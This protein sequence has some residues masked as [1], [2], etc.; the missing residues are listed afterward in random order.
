MNKASVVLLGLWVVFFSGS[1][2]LDLPESVAVKGDPGLY[3]PVGNIS[4]V[5]GENNIKISSY[6]SHEKIQEMMNKNDADSPI[7]VYE[8]EKS[9]LEA[10]TYLI[11]YPI[12]EMNLNLTEYVQAI[13]AA[14]S[15]PDSTEGFIQGTG[16]YISIPIPLGTMPQWI[17]TITNAQFTITLTMH[18]SGTVEVKFNKGPSADVEQ[19]KPFSEGGTVSFDS[20]PIPLFNPQ[21]G[22]T[23]SVKA[24]PGTSFSPS[25]D[26]DW[27]QAAVVPN[28][29]N[30]EGKFTGFLEDLDVTSLTRFL[31][32]VEFREVLGYVYVE[33]LPG[34]GSMAV[35]VDGDSLLDNGVPS[36]PIDP[37]SLPGLED[38]PSLGGSIGTINLTE[39]FNQDRSFKLGYAISM[40]EVTIQ[41]SSSLETIKADMV[42]KLPL[43]FLVSGEVVSL[44]DAAKYVK[45]DLKASNGNS[46]LPAFTDDL[47]GRKS[48]SS[49]NPIKS[50]D[51]ITV[52][53]KDIVNDVLPG[54]G[55]LITYEKNQQALTLT[56]GTTGELKLSDIPN[57]FIPRFDILLPAEESDEKGVLKIGRGNS[58]LD[59]FIAVEAK[60]KIEY[61]TTF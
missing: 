59:F 19:S 20:G 54:I 38:S 52:K 56:S 27:E 48:E 5:G 51:Y 33:G 30:E 22:I 55:L 46:M 34:A 40:E 11:H 25:F 16:G 15:I 28:N 12:A 13:D 24:P 45:L 43:E 31:G 41:K 42:I 60:A 2:A 4:E 26:F 47:F 37:Q 58:E 18:G 9:S 53:V 36:K 35:T 1:C 44:P 29:N 7:G 57:P 10:L 50:I 8:Y 49:D 23:I 21:E 17:K 61:T 39:L 3:V 14:K 6:I 32:D